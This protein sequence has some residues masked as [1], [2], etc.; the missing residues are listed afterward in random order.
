MNVMQE[1]AFG[2]FRDLLEDVTYHVWMA[3]YLTYINNAKA[4]PETGSAPDENYA[5]EV[6]Q[7]F[8]IGLLE[9]NRDGTLRRDG[10][11]NPIETYTQNDVTELA[12]VFTGLH[13]GGTDEFGTGQFFADRASDILRLEMDNDFHSPGTKE[14]LG[15]VIPEYSDGNQTISDA[16]DILAEHPNTAPFISKH[17]IQRLTTSN[18]SPSYVRAVADA[19]ISGRYR[20]PDGSVIGSREYGD[21]EATVAAVIFFEEA[22]GDERFT[23]ETYGK[24]REPILRITHWARVSGVDAFFVT[25][26][27][28]ADTIL[29]RLGQD[30]PYGARSVFNFFRPGYVATGSETAQASLVAP[31]LQIEFGPNVIEYANVMRSFTFNTPD[32]GRIGYWPNYEEVGL[33]DRASSIDDLVDYFNLIYTGN[34][35]APETIEVIKDTLESTGNDPLTRVRVASLLITN[36]IEYKTQ[37]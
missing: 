36:T 31:E 24:V 34:R 32:N 29:S 4:N 26:V 12:K 17:L 37:K 28:F 14:V 8:T 9:L 19:F 25:G 21:L 6:M 10:D 18:P 13:R 22:R 23:D 3:S 5:R 2:N 33:F 27:A 16:L 30:P 35:L 11:G 20:L 15:H 7:L 1:G